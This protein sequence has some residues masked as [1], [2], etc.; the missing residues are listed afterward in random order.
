MLSHYKLLFLYNSGKLNKSS[1]MENK[2]R[3]PDAINYAENKFRSTSLAK[4]SAIAEKQ[5]KK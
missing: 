4:T 5:L 2:I 1:P 3:N